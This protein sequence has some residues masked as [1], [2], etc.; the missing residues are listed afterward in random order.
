MKLF[1]HNYQYYYQIYVPNTRIL[2]SFR[3]PVV[4]ILC[5][6]CVI[7]RSCYTKYAIQNM[8]G[9][10]DELW[11]VPAP[12]C[13]SVRYFWSLVLYLVFF[14]TFVSAGTFFRPILIVCVA[15][16]GGGDGNL[17]LCFK[18]WSNPLPCFLVGEASPSREGKHPQSPGDTIKQINQS[19]T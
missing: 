3:I 8:N 16:A 18:F 12:Y 5:N 9:L 6:L 10:I 19:I 13:G 11:Q 17:I 4:I 14:V 1:N 15:R 2:P 7:C